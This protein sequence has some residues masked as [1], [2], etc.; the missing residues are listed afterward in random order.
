MVVGLGNPGDEYA[1]S[2]HN[3]GFQAIDALARQL[4]VNYWKD[5]CGAQLAIVSRGTDELILV[6]P[7]SFMNASGGPVKA[8][9]TL[10]DVAPTDIIVIH[11]EM[12][13]DPGTVRV[14]RGG[15]HAGHNGL[16][17]IIAKLG[18]DGFPRVRVGI[19]HPEGRRPVPD[20][21]LDRLKGPALESFQADC[22]RASD[23]AL[24][25]LDEGIQAAMNRFN[26]RG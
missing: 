10:Y 13:L 4:G 23:I 19:G 25:I 22:G 20:Y 26:I 21:V 24:V 11:D 5:Q 7:Q 6:K 8:A 9:A 3:A 1:D 18:T 16:K 12:D 17:S 15:G 2:R 14:K